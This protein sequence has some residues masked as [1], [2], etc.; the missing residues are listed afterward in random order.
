[1][2]Q[3]SLHLSRLIHENLSVVMCFVYSRRPL[4]NLVKENF[5]GEWKNLN[6]AL[7]DMSEQRAEKAC[8]ELAL[9]LRLWDDKEKVTDYISS[10][11]ESFSCGF[12]VKKNGTKDDLPFREVAN[13]IIHASCLQWDIPES[14]S[15]LL[16]CESVEEEKWVRAEVDIVRLARFCGGIMSY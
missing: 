11:G 2:A 6:K 8:L 16:I 15:P 4:Q 7:F 3:F 10:Q 1:M 12:L 14:G 13:K 5:T 9:F